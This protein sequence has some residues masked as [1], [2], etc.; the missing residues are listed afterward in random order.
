VA[1]LARPLILVIFGHKWTGSIPITRAI[2]CYTLFASLAIPPGT[3]LKVTRRT[4]LMVAFSIPVTGVLIVLLTI[5][6]KHGILTVALVTMA[7]QATIAPIQTI[8]VSR[9]LA[10]PLRASISE[11]IPPILAAAAMGSALVGIDHLISSPLEALLVGVPV[12]AAIYLGALWLMA[13][14]ELRALWRTAFPGAPVADQGEDAAV[15]STR[16]AR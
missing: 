6:T 9:Q 5:F 13:R 16:R 8:V 11:L 10:L 7:L 1:A 2:A 4:N 14:E 3:V 12:G 15:V